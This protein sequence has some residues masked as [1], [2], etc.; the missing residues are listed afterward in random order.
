MLPIKTA[1]QAGQ[2][3]PES[4]R[5]VLSKNLGYPFFEAVKVKE[6]DGEEAYSDA[7]VAAESS[8]VTRGRLA[9]EGKL[10][11]AEKDRLSVQKIEWDEVIMKLSLI[12]WI[13]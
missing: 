1:V 6:D 2:D 3:S 11:Q 13:V 5:L 4:A 12:G 10:L 9:G 8:V 7:D